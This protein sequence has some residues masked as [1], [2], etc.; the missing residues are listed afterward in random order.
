MLYNRDRFYGYIFPDHLKKA[1]VLLADGHVY[2]GTA[3]EIYDTVGFAN[4]SNGANT[5]GVVSIYRWPTY[6][7]GQYGAPEGE[8]EVV[9]YAYTQLMK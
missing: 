3:G 4:V 5:K 1:N 6:L 7:I 8:A 2:S 9:K